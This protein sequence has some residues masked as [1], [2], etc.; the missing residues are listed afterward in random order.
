M[1][2]ATKPYEQ[3]RAMLGNA[4]PAWEKLIGHIRFHYEMDEQWAEGKP[5]HKNRNNLY[6]R[7]GGKSFVIL[8][9]R[10]GYFMVCVVLGKEERERFDAQ[11]ETFGEA[12]CKEYDKA[13]TLHDGKWLGF[14]IYD[15]SLIDDIIRLLAIKRKP[16]RKVLPESAEK[17]GCLDL[18]LSH[19]E[20]TD[21]INP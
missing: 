18:G 9:I 19:E 8:A 2:R 5:T 13:E 6:I 1:N 14:D 20:I 10:E 12:I 16:N 7:R 4:S 11:R 21:L 15:E 3:V 17:C